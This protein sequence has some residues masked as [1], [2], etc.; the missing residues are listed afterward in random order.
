[1]DDLILTG[2]VALLV[3]YAGLLIIAFAVLFLGYVLVESIL[4]GDYESFLI[5]TGSIIGAV[6]L[7]AATGFLLHRKGII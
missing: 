3:L 1:M 5:I 2:V 6:A 7:Y 4:S